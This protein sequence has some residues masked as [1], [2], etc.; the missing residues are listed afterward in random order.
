MTEKKLTE[1]DARMALSDHAIKKAAQL[2]DR[3]GGEMTWP[4]F[5]ALLGDAE[6]IRYPCR[7]TFGAEALEPGEFAWPQPLGE[8][9]QDGFCLWLHPKFEGRD[10]DCLLLAAYQLVVVNYGEV[11]NHEA[12]ELFGAT[13]CG[14]EREA[15]YERVC[16]LAD[17]V[18][19][20]TE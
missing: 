4:K 5:L 1:E 11:A 10:A 19:S 7:V 12:A 18:I 20:G 16:A 17:E 2:R 9:P 3:C 6:A 15:Y 14:M 13:L 8:K